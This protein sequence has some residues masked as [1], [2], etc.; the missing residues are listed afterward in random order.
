MIGNCT[1]K[2][3][4]VGYKLNIKLCC[5]TIVRLLKITYRFKLKKL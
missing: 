3:S 4:F 5:I 2:K 1:N